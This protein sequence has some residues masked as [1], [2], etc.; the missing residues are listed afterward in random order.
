MKKVLS[1][2]AALMLFVSLF[3]GTTVLAA[4]VA[5]LDHNNYYSQTTRTK[6]SQGQS[7]SL[8]ISVDQLGDNW[9]DAGLSIVINSNLQNSLPTA[10]WQETG[11]NGVFTYTFYKSTDN[12]MVGAIY[13]CGEGSGSTAA[14][15]WATA[16]L[17]GNVKIEVKQNSAGVTALFLNNTEWV[18]HTSSGLTIPDGY[19]AIATSPGSKVTVKASQAA[20]SQTPQQPPQE[21]PKPSLAVVNR[22]GYEGAT[23]TSKASGLLLTLPNS[24][25]HKRLNS[26]KSYNLDSFNIK[27]TGI[28]TPRK[29]GNDDWPSSRLSLGFARDADGWA[30]GGF[31]VTYNPYSGRFGIAVEGGS[32]CPEIAGFVPNGQTL[33][34][35]IKKI[36]KDN[37]RI[38]ANGQA[39]TVPARY[40]T[41]NGLNP[42][43]AY[44]CFGGSR[45]EPWESGVNGTI[46]Y[47]VAKMG[48]YVDK[49]ETSTSTTTVNGNDGQD[50]QS[51]IVNRAAY[52]GAVIDVQADGV[53]LTLPNSH[54]YKRLNSQQYYGLNGF[55]IR[56]TGIVTPRKT[57]NDDWTS[58]RLALGFTKDVDGW[59]GGGFVVTYNPYSGRFAIAVEGVADCPEIAGFIAAGDSLDIVMK[60]V[61][62]ENWQIKANEQ[63]FTVPAR[64]FAAN[65]LNA[66]QAYVC[67]AGSRWETWDK[68]VDGTIQYTVAKMEQETVASDATTTTTTNVAVN[69]DPATLPAYYIVVIVLAV[70]LVA[71]AAAFVVI[72]LK[73]KNAATP[74][75]EPVEEN[76][77]TETEDTAE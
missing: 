43:K 54:P 38:S 68:N 26:E 5:T 29:T 57:G 14:A 20:V 48:Y 69:T 17:V 15:D 3:S 49:G 59:A 12:K 47:T 32:N 51:S 7:A 45:W 30:G 70:L 65:G 60:K 37:W 33:D 19:L 9:Y 2:L 42:S 67:F 22:T 73:R 44:V 27:L 55:H 28:S 66:D 24:H 74:V 4:N 71:A 35:R 16:S 36:D 18:P 34:L 31:V 77:K 40:F 21:D 41:A 11:A 6:F 1:V 39:F 56:L 61:D 10:V 52:E 58:S 46:S 75:T 23:I 72:L 53:H 25:P 63:D 76:G 50:A 64:Y 8:T 62:D 13:R